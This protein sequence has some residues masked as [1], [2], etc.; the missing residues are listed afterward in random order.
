MLT[1]VFI[2]EYPWPKG[3]PYPEFTT[4]GDPSISALGPNF[5]QRNPGDLGRPLSEEE[6]RRIKRREL[7]LYIEGAIVYEDAFQKPRHSKYF[8]YTTGQDPEQHVVRLGTVPDEL[9]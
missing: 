7:A 5:A 3:K 9:D 4:S 8:R 6:A 2:D 1:K